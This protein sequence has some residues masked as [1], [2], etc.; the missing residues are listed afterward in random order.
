[1]L[2]KNTEIIEKAVKL[3]EEGLSYQKIADKISEEIWKTI[4]RETI[5]IWLKNRIWDSLEWI[6]KLNKEIE[7]ENPFVLVD[8][9]VVFY[10]KIKWTDTIK[11]ISI[12]IDEI[13]Q[14]REDYVEV[15][16]NLTWQEIM[17]K[18]NLNPEAWHLLKNRLGLYKKSNI[19]P[20]RLLKKIESEEWEDKA[21]KVI[22]EVSYKAAHD[23]YR[24]LIVKKYNKAKNIEYEKAI[25]TLYNIENF[26]EMLHNFLD[27]YN[28][29]KFKDYDDIISSHNQNKQDD[30]DNEYNDEHDNPYMIDKKNIKKTDTLYT[31]I[32]DLH[33]W[34]E[35]TDEI[36]KRLKLFVKD[37]I[38]KKENK[39]VLFILWDLVESVIIWGKH[40]NIAEHM[41]WPYWFDLIMKT[42]NILENVITE[43]YK[44]WKDIEVYWIF[45]NHDTF[46]KV[47]NLDWTAWLV[48]YE[49]I[50][51]GIDKL[52]IK[53]K[54][55]RK[56]WNKVTTEDFVFIINHGTWPHTKKKAQ[57][58]LWEFWDNNKENIILQWDK[59]HW[60]LQNVSKNGTRIL[61]PALAWQWEYDSRLWVSSMTGFTIIKKWHNWKPK[62]EF[63]FFD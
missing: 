61:V 63:I 40:P 1:M 31:T 18:Y 53:L 37:I 45:G 30:I 12:P 11:K 44:S 49:M 10:K 50:K 59:H 51:R 15:W 29:E 41:D 13:K 36:I 5:R 17:E 7:Y 26:L 58:I 14:I 2:K 62:V 38:E 9:D 60:E 23:K 20:S 48:I 25:T 33:I 46:D 34:K 6:K 55:Y 32:T 8:N 3:R 54:Y 56:I 4:S 22:E 27:N 42:V 21:K 52:W 35:N 16:T 57:D 24:R 28:P 47:D 19:I 39:V 43:I